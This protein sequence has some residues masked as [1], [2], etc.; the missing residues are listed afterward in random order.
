MRNVTY[1]SKT[2]RKNNEILSFGRYRC[3]RWSICLSSVPLRNTGAVWHYGPFK[4]SVRFMRD[5]HYVKVIKLNYCVIYLS[6]TS[7]DLISDLINPSSLDEHRRAEKKKDL[8]SHLGWPREII[9]K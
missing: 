7:S 1:G 3:N 2:I 4:D 8:L 9:I 6:I 5:M